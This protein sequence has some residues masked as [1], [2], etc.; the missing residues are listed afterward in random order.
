MKRCS[1][2]KQEKDGVIF[3]VLDPNC[4]LHREEEETMG[5]HSGE[6]KMKFREIFIPPKEHEGSKIAWV[7]GILIAMILMVAGF[8]LV[9]ALI[10]GTVRLFVWFIGVLVG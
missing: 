3:D 1:C 9:G 6:R 4:F 8:V 7:I 5:E 10:I 2:I